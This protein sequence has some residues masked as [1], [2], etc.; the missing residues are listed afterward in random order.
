MKAIPLLTGMMSGSMG[1]CT[2]AHNRGGM[3]FR[4][5]V[6]PTNPNSTRQQNVRSYLTSAVNAWSSL[7]T[8]AQRM[9]WSTWAAN[10]A[11]T[12]TLGQTFFLTGQQAFNRYHVPAFQLGRS[13]LTDAPA[14][15]DNG[16]PIAAITGVL[17]AP[18]GTIGVTAAAAAM[19][20]SANLMAAAP[21]DGDVLVYLGKPLNEARHYFKGPY[22][23]ATS[24]PLAAAAIAAEITTI[25]ASQTQDDPLIIAQFRPIRFRVA[26]DDGRLSAPYEI[27]GQV[28][29]DS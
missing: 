14:D 18:A 9:T 12:D 20:I 27:I 7:L 26:Y 17:A 8:A 4:Q 19:S 6:V 28:T 25:A 13:V 23:L 24:A 10:V 22:Q 16:Q 1:G 21:D 3:Y 15:F 5:R 29:L 2:A 11:F